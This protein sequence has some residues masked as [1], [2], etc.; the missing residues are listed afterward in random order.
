MLCLVD[1]ASF[2]PNFPKARPSAKSRLYSLT[3]LSGRL[4]NSRDIPFH[5]AFRAKHLVYS[6]CMN[7]KCTLM[8]HTPYFVRLLFL[9][10]LKKVSWEV[11]GDSGDSCF[12]LI[13]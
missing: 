9:H 7:N 8:L 2:I 5:D 1:L 10:R 11:G 3:R 13:I 12:L 4:D 6:G